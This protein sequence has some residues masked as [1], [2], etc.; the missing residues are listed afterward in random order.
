MKVKITYEYE[1]A[2]GAKVVHFVIAKDDNELTEY[3]RRLAK[4]GY[5]VISVKHI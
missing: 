4:S 2:M 3:V 5:D 1:S